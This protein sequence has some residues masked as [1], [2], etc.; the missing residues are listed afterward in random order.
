MSIKDIPEAVLSD[1]HSIRMLTFDPAQRGEALSGSLECVQID[2]AGTYEPLSYDWGK[3]ARTHTIICSGVKLPL[4]SSLYHALRRVRL[5][6]KSRRVWVDQICIDQDDLDE[7]S[8]QVQF[9]N[10]IYRK[11]SM[12]LVWLGEDENDEASAAFQ[13]VE[14]L[15][16]TFENDEKH[17]EFHKDHI[18]N[19]HDRNGEEW[20]PLKALTKILWASTYVFYKTI[21]KSF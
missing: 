21:M 13:L 12:V 11:A 16:E 6:L 14:E 3:P 2:D 18:E 10:A 19:L 8:Q 1:E 5:P 15:A 20:K 7:R 4:T 17:S 9:M